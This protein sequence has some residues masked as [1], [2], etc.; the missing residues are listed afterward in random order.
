MKCVLF[1]DKCLDPISTLTYTKF[2]YS[3][4]KLGRGG[5]EGCKY[6]IKIESLAG[7]AVM[8]VE[9]G[10]QFSVALTRSGAVYTWGKGLNL[11]FS[12]RLEN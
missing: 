7:L 1:C 11:N 4:G 3:S 2:R 9:C 10:S 12:T 6:P 5:S 8:K